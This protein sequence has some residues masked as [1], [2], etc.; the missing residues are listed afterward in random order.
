[1]QVKILKTKAVVTV[2]DFYEMHPTVAFPQPLTND[3]LETFGAILVEP[4]ED[5]EAL[6]LSTRVEIEQWRDRQERE[7]IVF[8]FN[9]RAW[10]G[11]V[12]VRERLQP[13][14]SLKEL[15]EG[16]FW[17]DHENNDVPMSV[18]ELKLLSSAHEVALVQK[19]FEIHARQRQMKAEISNMTV[20]ELKVF[21]PS[22]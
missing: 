10:D 15:P 22:W 9:G 16:F 7:G 2:S 6:K 20:Q 12:K 13:V 11:G 14:L 5:I 19:G 17:T 4:E 8:V 3:I 18:E 21:S 1:M